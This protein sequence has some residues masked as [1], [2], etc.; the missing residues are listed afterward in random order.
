MGRFLE[1]LCQE[2]LYPVEPYQAAQYLAGPYQAVLYRMRRLL[3]ERC[4]EGPY[5]A[6]QCPAKIFQ[7]KTHEQR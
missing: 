3:E 5:Q 7:E 4:R 2:V 6:V 1:E